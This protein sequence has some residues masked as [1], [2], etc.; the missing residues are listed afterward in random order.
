MEI[1]FVNWNDLEELEIMYNLKDGGMSGH[2]PGYHWFYDD[3]TGI[4]VYVK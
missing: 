4:N 1:L 2:Y 3:Y